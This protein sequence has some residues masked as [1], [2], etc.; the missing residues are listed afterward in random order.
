MIVLE[1]LIIYE[2]VLV[3]LNI[4]KIPQLGQDA[5][6]ILVLQVTRYHMHATK[7]KW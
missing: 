5:M 3:C 1:P 2:L 7:A 6:I 4:G